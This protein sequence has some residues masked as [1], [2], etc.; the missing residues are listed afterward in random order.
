MTWK[1]LLIIWATIYKWK[2]LWLKT[3]K[4]KVKISNQINQSCKK[5]WEAKENYLPINYDII[6]RFSS[7]IKFYSFQLLSNYLSLN[8]EKNKD[9]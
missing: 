9:S 3:W 8:I 4:L 2:I 5:L 1:K 6:I 7:L